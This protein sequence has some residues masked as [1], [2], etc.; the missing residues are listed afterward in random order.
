MTERGTPLGELVTIAGGGTPNRAEPSYWGSGIPWASVKDLVDLDLTHTQEFI[1]QAG[2]DHSAATLVPA[3]S[4]IVATRMALGKAVINTVDLAINQDLKALTCGPDLDPHYLLYFLLSQAARLERMGKGATVKGITL[5][6]LRDLVVP[7]PSLPKQRRIAAV[8][9]KVEQ[10][11]RKRGEALRLSGEFLRSAFLEMFGDPVRNERD[12]D[13]K[14]LGDIAVVTT[15]NTPPRLNAGYYGGMIEWIKSDNINTLDHYVTKA[16]EGLS[17]EGRH[18]A[19]TV[20]PQ[21]ILMTCIAGSRDCIGN[22][23][24]TDR[25][26]AFNQQ[27][28]GIEPQTGTDYRFLYVQFLVGKGL[29]QQSSTDSMKGLVSKSRLQAVQVLTPPFQLQKQFGEW[30]TRWHT[31]YSK[32]GQAANAVV[33][34]FDSLSRRAFRGELSPS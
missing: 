34:L 30:F 10:V 31:I 17:A 4:V 8:L 24:I 11:R 3:G 14:A 13:R 2:L 16:K 5:D 29:V 23:A 22:V 25:E 27:I 21:A 32:Q 6:R 15:G 12:W 26:V 7:L 19:R 28:N 33:E 1:T 9:D 18:M 20:G